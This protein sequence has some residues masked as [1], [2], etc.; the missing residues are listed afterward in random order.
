MHDHVPRP[1]MVREQELIINVMADKFISQD[2]G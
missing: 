2:T 1:S